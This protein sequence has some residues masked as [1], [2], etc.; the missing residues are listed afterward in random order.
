MTQ[1]IKIAYF[2]D[3]IAAPTGG[4]EKQL[5][6]LL[7][8]L[9]RDKISP[10]LFCFYQ[11]EWMKNQTFSFP[12]TYLN[13]HRLFGPD[14]YKAYKQFKQVHK[15]EQFDIAQTFFRDGNIFGTAAAHWAKVDKIISSRRNVGYWHDRLHLT[16][17]RKLEKWTSYYLSN[18]QA[19]VDMTID[20]ELADPKKF[21]IIYNGLDLD[22]FKQIDQ[23]T[24]KNQ[25]EKW[26]ISNDDIVIGTVAN[27]RP[28]KRIDTII[29]CA[30]SLKKDYPQL[31]F[32][33][34]GE[35]GDRS[36]LEA[37][38]KEQGVEDRIIMPGSLDDVVP[39]LA[40]FDIAVLPS[41]NESFSNSL[42][43]YMA[44]K[45]PIA[46]TKVGGN[47]EAIDHNQNGLLYDLDDSNGLRDALKLLLDNKD[48]AD[49]MAE[50]ACRK[51]HD[52][53]SIKIMIENHEKF[54][55]SISAGAL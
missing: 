37:L 10:H 19:A 16:I 22:R 17:L 49:K 32:V 7:D 34:I 47:N 44:A 31:K 55:N 35:G 15:T 14:F 51:A 39:A 3:T 25:R 23:T 40:V 20:T 5:L 11:S 8:G 21:K 13:L 52:S 1:P 18:S 33:I 28:V 53:Y 46:A 54:Y 27:L 9:N 2:I 24:K 36:Q 29:H 45:L 48:K 38:A 41:S 30:A 50:N 26:N 6:Y 43:E 42:I 12:V 4:T